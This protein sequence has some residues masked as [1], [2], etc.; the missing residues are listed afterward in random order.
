M[1]VTGLTGAL[2][3]ATGL[4]DSMALTTTGGLSVWG[5]NVDG[6]LGI[7]SP[8]SSTVA[9]QGPQGLIQ[10]YD[11]T[12]SVSPSNTGTIS[13]VPVSPGGAYAAGSNVCLT[14]APAAGELFQSWTGT[15]LNAAN[16]LTITGNASITANFKTNTNTKKLRFIPAAPCRV[17][18]TRN[19]AGPLGGPA[20]GAGATRS[21]TIPGACGIPSTAL[22]YSLNL[23]VVPN[24]TL[25]YITLWPTGQAQP[26]VST[27][28]SIDGRVKS[29]AAIVPAGT[30]GAVSVYATNSTNVILDIDGYFDDASDASAL[31]F[32]PLTPCRVADTRN[33]VGQLG[34]PSLIGN[35][36][37]IFPVLSSSCNIPTN[38]LAYSLN[39]TAVP[40][41]PLGYLTVWPSGQNRPV[42]STLNAP[43]AAVTANAAIVPAGSAGAIEL[44]VT[45]NTDMV[46]DIDGYFASAGSGGYSLYNLPPCRI[47]DTRLPSGTPPFTGTIAV[48]STGVPCGVPPEARSLVLNGTVVPSGV[49]GYLTL[50]ANG[51][52]QPVVSTLNSLDGSITSNMALVPT[53]NGLVNAYAAGPAPTFLILDISSYF[54]P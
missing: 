37:R 21:F 2:A 15:A 49:L 23:T 44:F 4:N 45:N 11:L 39:F 25:G 22:A 20:I 17:V 51:G 40:Q 6:Q 54:A 14:A 31:E 46:I 8:S 19:P 7:Q 12:T 50:W 26:V 29:N 43:T 36:S 24:G 16:C 33:A 9:I 30:A 1:Q 41:G 48:T 18:D 27:L 52:P 35:N 38:A 53:T 42:V 5:S 47:K 13:I 10:I 28:N 32:Y 34:G 3:V